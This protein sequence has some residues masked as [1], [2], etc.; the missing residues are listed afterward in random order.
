VL[1]FSVAPFKG[2]NYFFAVQGM[3][4]EF[5]VVASNAVGESAP[6]TEKVRMPDGGRI[7]WTHSVECWEKYDHQTVI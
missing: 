7:C 6:S 3:E 5:S 4:Y 2:N 1:A